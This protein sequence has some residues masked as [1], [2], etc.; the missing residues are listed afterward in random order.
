MYDR[1]WLDKNRA[2]IMGEKGMTLDI[3]KLR[4]QFLKRLTIDSESK[5]RRR[6]GYNQA[7]FNAEKGY[8]IWSSTDLEMVMDK[9]DAAVKD[10]EEK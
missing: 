10:L 6:K 3:K 4:E 1:G 5:D 7:I 2:V 8:A 9:F